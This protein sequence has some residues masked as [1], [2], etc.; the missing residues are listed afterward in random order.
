MAKLQK[1]RL[2]RRR[3]A[4]GVS[5]QVLSTLRT[6]H[7]L[8]L[9]KRLPRLGKR[10]RTATEE[11]TIIDR[12]ILTQLLRIRKDDGTIVIINGED[13]TERDLPQPVIQP[14]GQEPG[15][16]SGNG[17]NRRERRRPPDPKP[18]ARAKSIPSKPNRWMSL[19]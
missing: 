8:R 17:N 9:N 5:S 12:Q 19:I 15:D 18:E 10:V 2:I 6:R 14:A 7:L 13:I 1:A 4:A 16:R 11:G 3:S